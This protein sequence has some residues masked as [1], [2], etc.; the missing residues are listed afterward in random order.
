MQSEQQK[1]RSRLVA[2]Q[3]QD[4]C[5]SLTVPAGMIGLVNPVTGRPKAEF[6]VFEV[7]IVES[8]GVEMIPA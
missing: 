1:V 6:Q 7:A 4:A 3:A 5:N 8:I 2:T